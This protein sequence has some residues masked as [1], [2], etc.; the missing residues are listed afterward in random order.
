MVSEQRIKSHSKDFDPDEKRPPQTIRPLTMAKLNI[1]TKV[2]LLV[3]AEPYYSSYGG[4]PKVIIKA[5]TIGTVM[6]VDVPKVRGK[7][8]FICVD[9]ILPGIFQG[10]PKHN[11]CTWRCGISPKQVKIQ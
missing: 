9:F 11:N 8:T 10:D 1:G 7:G 4:N 5:E 3:D 2:K 6:A